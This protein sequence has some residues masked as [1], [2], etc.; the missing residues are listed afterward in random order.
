V[1]K[2]LGRVVTESDEILLSRESRQDCTGIGQPGLYG[3]IGEGGYGAKLRRR[4]LRG[5]QISALLTI[6]SC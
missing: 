2:V 3:R 5:V 1:D 4:N 6:A